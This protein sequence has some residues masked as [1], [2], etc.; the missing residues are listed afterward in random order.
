M[1]LGL[2]L[3][4]IG[5]RL[6]GDVLT[7]AA[8]YIPLRYRTAWPASQHKSRVFLCARPVP[9]LHPAAQAG[10]HGMVFD[11]PGDASLVV[12][13]ANS[14]VEVIF[15]PESR[16]API[17]QPICVACT[18]AFNAPDRRSETLIAQG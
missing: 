8:L 4:S 7:R 12:L 11:L 3:K 1:V 6:W 16:T 9:I 18:T 2:R 17:Q 10:S 13:V 14:A 15:R 5:S